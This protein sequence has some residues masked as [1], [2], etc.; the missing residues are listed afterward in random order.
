VHRQRLLIGALVFLATLLVA[1]CGDQGLSKS[2]QAVADSL[3]E[4][5]I[6]QS[7]GV[8]NKKEAGC[9]AEA[10][11]KSAGV[12]TLKKAGLVSDKGEAVAAKITMTRPVATQFADAVL[13]CVDF[14]DLTARQIA[15]LRPD[16]R[17]AE[18]SACVREKVSKK[19]ARARLIAQQMG[20]DKSSAYKRT[21]AELLQCAEDAN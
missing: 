18:F 3:A 21:N 4:Y 10:F 20:D 7:D 19:D 17:T 9:M 8:W 13:A 14:A 6:A 5:A 1:G 12:P 11:V 2:D 15:N 16:I